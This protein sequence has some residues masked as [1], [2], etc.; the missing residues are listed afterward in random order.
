MK[1]TTLNGL[2]IRLD[3]S[4]GNF[5]QLS[6]KILTDKNLTD[7]GLR[8][9]MLLVDTPSTSKISLTYYRNLLGWSKDKL[10]GATKNLTENGYLKITQHP[11]E[12]RKDYVYTY[13][14]NE[15]GTLKTTNDENGHMIKIHGSVKP[16][17]KEN[18]PE[19]KEVVI[20]PIV[21]EIKSEPTNKIKLEDYFENISN[22]M[23]PLDLSDEVITNIFDYFDNA[24]ETGK[25]N[26]PELLTDENIRLIINK[27]APSIS[28]DNLILELCDINAGG[29]GITAEN[30]KE[31]T[32]K[33]TNY[34][35][36]NPNNIIEYAIKNKIMSIKASYSKSGLLDQKY[37]N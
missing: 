37:Q 33:V 25:L 10:S 15:F 35:K 16:H 36:N 5:L 20:P 11:K 30:K 26:D 34:F 13:I 4:E 7:T 8:L 17:S 18:N 9:L 21:I 27:F 23:T 1:K 29:K 12:T 22:L 2:I 3:Y 6:K 31:I 32:N 14:V 24:I 19:P 28:H